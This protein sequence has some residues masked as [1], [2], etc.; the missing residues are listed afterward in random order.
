MAIEKLKKFEQNFDAK[1][2]D[3]SLLKAL[4]VRAVLSYLHFGIDGILHPSPAATPQLRQVQ[5]AVGESVAGKLSYLIPLIAQCDRKELGA[6]AAD[7]IS[8]ALANDPE[9]RQMRYLT[10]YAQFCAVMPDV[11]RGN[12][13]VEDDN[14]GGFVLKHLS[15]DQSKYEMI[16]IVLSEL[17][18]TH[19][20]E[21]VPANTKYFDALTSKMS[22]GG[23]VGMASMYKDFYQANVI[24]DPILSDDGY[25]AATG[26]TRIEFDSFRASLLGIAATCSGVAKAF[27]RRYRLHPKNKQLEHEYLEWVTVNWDNKFFQGALMTLS[28]LKGEQLDA[29]LP[30]F[31]I[32]FRGDELDIRHAN[33]GYFPPLA[34]IQN[35]VFFNPSLLQMF[36]PSRN[37]LYALNW[38]DKNRFDSLVSSHMEPELVKSAT[39]IFKR[40]DGVVVVPNV[41]WQQGEIAGELDLLVFSASEN[42]ALH[43]QA[44]AAIPPQGARMVAAL[45][46]RIA[47]GTS[48]LKRFRQLPTNAI[49]SIISSSI[50][51][52]LNNVEI[53]DVILTRSSCGTYRVWGTLDEVVVINLS[54]LGTVQR[55]SVLNKCPDPLKKFPQTVLEELDRVMHAVKPKWTT[56]TV[57][58]G[59]S[60][61]NIPELEYNRQAMDRVRTAMARAGR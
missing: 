40:F 26:V 21:S 35:A 42:I 59:D 53:I 54:L 2:K 11:W 15:E 23:V 28:G 45:E 41:D 58:W 25:L 47:E 9:M 14:N 10:E 12:Y 49:D 24:E 18:L 4:P 55:Q 38:L 36:L 33:D 22:L 17:S 56:R 50:G 32:D 44:K 29:L 43:V 48:Q 52:A 1:V 60:S 61:F 13:L 8:A 46:R 27:L 57:T 16:D 3:L 51:R 31:S 39:A 37:I 20:S 5:R 19:L 30:L 6:D 7:A 34:W